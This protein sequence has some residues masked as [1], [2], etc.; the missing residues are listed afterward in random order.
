MYE[1]M[2]EIPLKVGTDTDEQDKEK[3]GPS[4]GVVGALPQDYAR[5]Q[6][7]QGR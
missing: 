7:L 6:G 1:C 5:G 4:A 2:C 3:A